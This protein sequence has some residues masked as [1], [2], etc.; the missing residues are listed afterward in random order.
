[1]SVNGLLHKDEAMS[2]SQAWQHTLIIPGMGRQSL[3]DLWGFRQR[4]EDP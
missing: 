4:L 3:E 1:L 2:L